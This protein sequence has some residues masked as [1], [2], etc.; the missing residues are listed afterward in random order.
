MPEG[1]TLAQID[2]KSR[3]ALRDPEW[4]QEQR[5]D[6]S[7]YVLIRG[8]FDQQQ[9]GALSASFRIKR[10]YDDATGE[11]R[12][13]ERIS[14]IWR[15]PVG[16]FNLLHMAERGSPLRPSKKCETDFLRVHQFSRPS[17]RT[18]QTFV[19]GV[20]ATGSNSQHVKTLVGVSAK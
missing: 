1:E 2:H 20:F 10:E 8:M 4:T 16:D 14:H 15:S 9:R 17:I 6:S 3:T 13:S 12:E 5:L 11:L 18:A 7:E 19:A